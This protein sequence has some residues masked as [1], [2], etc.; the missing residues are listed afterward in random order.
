M[1]TLKGKEIV[2]INLIQDEKKDKKKEVFA[3]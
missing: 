1:K 2:K 3:R